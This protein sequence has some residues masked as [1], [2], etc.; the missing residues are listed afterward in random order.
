MGLRLNANKSRRLLLAA[1]GA[2][3]LVMVGCDVPLGPVTRTPVEAVR[4]PETSDPFVVAADGA[5]FVYGS[6]NHLRAPVTRLTDLSRSYSLQEKNSLTVEGMPTKPAWTASSTQLWAPTVER[7]GDR[8]IMWFSAD[9]VGAPDPANRQCIGRAFASSPSG[10]FAPE[11]SP[12]HCGID[13]RGALD[14]NVF[15]DAMGQRWLLVAFGNT[16]TPIHIIALDGN[17]NFSGY[18]TAI[19]GRRHPW[20]YHFIENPSMVYDRVRNNYLLSYSAGRWWESGYSTGIARCASPTGPCTS[21]PAGPWISSSNGRTGPG[22]L[23]FF[24]DHEGAQRAIYSSFAAGQESTNGG[25]SASVTYLKV[26]PSVNL[27]VVK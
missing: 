14:P 8:W 10:P 25:R 22:G 5:Y 24:Q 20:E 26:D 23:S 11:P 9:R 21:D 16:E 17:G 6:N 13:G 15:T 2:C 4:L 7:F 12:V 18:P 3:A 1:V 27:T 19:L